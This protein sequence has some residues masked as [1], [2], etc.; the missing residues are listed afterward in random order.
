MTHTVQNITSY[1]N[2][3]VGSGSVVNDVQRAYSTFQQ[4]AIEY[5]SHSGAA[6]TAG[7]LNVQYQYADGSANTI[8]PTELEYPNGRQLNFDYGTSGGMGDLL[9]RISAIDD[10]DTALATYTYLGLST[11]VQSNYAQPSI[12]MTFIAQGSEPVGDAGD[13]YVGLDRFGRT[14]DN[15]WIN[16]SAADI[17]RIKYGY[18]QASNR[19]WRQNTV[20]ASGQDEYYNYDGLYQVDQLQRGTLNSE[21]T[22]IS[23]TPAWEEDFTYDP[24]LNLTNYV[25]KVSGTTELNQDRTHSEVN[26]V[27][28]ISGSASLVGFDAAGNMTQSPQ[29]ANWSAAN[30]LK[31]DAWNRLVD[32]AAGSTTVATYAY[33]GLTRRILKTVS[34]EVIDYYYSSQWQVLEERD[35]SL[36]SSSSSEDGIT[37]FVWGLQS[38]DEVIL[39]DVITSETTRVYALR[40]AMHVTAITDTTGSVLERYGYEAFGTTDVMNADFSPEDA[41]SYK[42][43]IRF[44]SYLWDS[45]SGFYQVRNRYLHPTLARWLS[46]DPIQEVG[47]SNLYVYVHNNPLARLDPTGLQWGAIAGGIVGGLFGAAAGALG[48]LVSQALSGGPINLGDVEGAAAGGAL[49][50]AV[51]G[52]IGVSIATA[53]PAGIAA[54]LAEAAA[55]ASADV[56]AT[57]AAG[58]SGEAMLGSLAAADA[59]ATAAEGAAAAYDAAQAAA[60][61]G[62]A[63]G[64]VLSVAAT[65]LGAELQAVVSG[66]L[67]GTGGVGSGGGGG[68]STP[69]VPV[70]PPNNPPNNPWPF[71]PPAQPNQPNQPNNPPAAPPGAPPP[72]CGG[73]GGGVSDQGLPDISGFA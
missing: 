56:A 61:A 32:V 31:Y 4:L 51:V 39:R 21:Q 36:S 62:V 53:D 58:A 40:D 69:L 43:E 68:G 49:V 24:N 33:D 70:G 65:S 9:S 63:Q 66:L 64:G 23:G 17:D 54:S 34:G 50:G 1:D 8:R 38:G 73:V 19:Q 59:A 28:T 22:G 26:E 13:Q 30:T 27:L 72:D 12:E 35:S 41:S 44:C 5:Q 37:Q 2:A 7:T 3:A 71:N 48:S 15:R 42:W 47:G 11:I 57:A 60:V 20:A 55:L 29:P 16:G 25:T 14:V 52:A 46:R 18:D 45:E 67:G 6:N 10:G